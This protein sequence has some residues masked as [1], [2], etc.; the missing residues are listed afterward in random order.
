MPWPHYLLVSCLTALLL[1]SGQAR[2]EGIGEWATQASREIAQQIRVPSV[3]RRPIG[4]PTTI[5]QFLVNRTGNVSDIVVVKG[6]GSA[7]LDDAVIR[8][9]RSARPLPFPPM[10]PNTSTLKATLPITFR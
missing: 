9:V 6:S 5:V 8:A 3:Y 7:D 1:G 10:P 4:P 2:S